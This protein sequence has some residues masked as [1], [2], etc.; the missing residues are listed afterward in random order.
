MSLYKGAGLLLLLWCVGRPQLWAQTG[1][2]ADSVPTSKELSAV[3]VTATRSDRKL[4]DVPI[5]VTIIDQDQI[6]S[7]GASR[8]D[9]ILA[10]QTGLAIINDH[11]PGVQVQG[12]DPEYCLILINGEPVI[13]RTAGTLD[14]TRI[15]LSDVERIEIIKGPA[16]SL[17]G[18]DALA[19][20]INIITKSYQRSG[21]RVETQYGSYGTLDNTLTAALAMGEKGSA[22]VSLNRYHTDGYDLMKDSYG[23]T[24]FPYTDYTLQ[25]ALRY[26][27]TPRLQLQLT[28]RYF[29]E[30]MANDFLATFEKDTVTVQGDSKVKDGHISP[31]FSYR[32]SPVW[33]MKLRS[34]W[35]GYR[36][37][38]GLYDIHS[39][40][41]YD[42]AYFQQRLW[43]EELQ[44]ENVLSPRQVLTTGLGL[45]DQSVAA[46]RYTEKEVMRD[47][48]FYAQHEWRPAA[49]WNIL[50]GLRY[51]HPSAYHPQLSPKVAAQF[52][53]NKR[54]KFQ[55][56]VGMGYKAPDFRQLYL[57]FSNPIVGY[58]VLGT[59]QV[60]EQL[61][62]MQKAGQIARVYMDPETL[63][64]DLK[65][66][67]SIA[68]NLGGTYQATAG[69]QLGIH[70]FRNDIEDLID[71]RTIAMKTN[72]QPLYSY[73]NVHRV[74]TE[75]FEANGQLPL[76]G[77]QLVLKAG[78]QFL[79]ARD[80]QVVEDI[81]AGK[82][83]IRDPETLET[84]HLTMADYGGLFNRS[85]HTLQ[86]RLDYRYRDW[87]FN[88][89][90]VYRS[91]FGFADKNGDNLLDA[92]NEY[93][94]GYAVCHLNVARL[95][96]QQRLD[97]QAGVK[98]LFDYTDPEHLS[99]LP[100]RTFYVRVAL[101]LFKNHQNNTF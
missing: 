15:S 83:F 67:S 2:R 91:R 10:E 17:Y 50:S 47:Y 32:F 75:G 12:M 40:T 5:P 33:K 63:Q 29:N 73:Y 6:Q 96:W 88:T 94:P 79:L 4:A 8:L 99:Y 22:S 39:D 58:S 70:L 86:L 57:T 78:Y 72:G 21:V 60:K 25:A 38:N 31:V 77:R 93:A 66:E 89:R 97:V 7:S 11:G 30:K 62:E 23:K 46:T 55:G 19:G 100:G 64:S 28:G 101:H 81:Q 95:F 9:E 20:V 26:Q 68:Y 44:S 18:S 76:L 48:F 85:T 42:G 34:Y 52:N 56:S 82:R 84:R 53:M 71:T 43:K 3:V 49:R 27:I 65:P 37:N 98:D 87:T 69:W 1:T 45:N 59:K 54:W 74:Y 16:S 35:S 14:L 51:D 61:A 36:T 13:G 24:V 92:D 80:K 41:L 90:V